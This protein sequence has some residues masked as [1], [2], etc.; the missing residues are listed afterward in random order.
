MVE[1]LLLEDGFKIVLE[2][3]SGDVLLE[4]SGAAAGGMLYRARLDGIGGRFSRD[5]GGTA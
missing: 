5:L 1:Y 3:G 2:D 4:S